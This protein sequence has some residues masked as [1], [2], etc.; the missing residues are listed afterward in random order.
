[1][2]VNSGLKSA[3]CNKFRVLPFDVNFILLK[4]D[5]KTLTSRI[6]ERE[7]HF[8][9][10]DLLASQLAAMEASDNEND[11]LEICDLGSLKQTINTIKQEVMRD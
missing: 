11:V 3:H 4:A 1:M 9:S 5:E 8:L 6:L 7:P 10:A 2:Q